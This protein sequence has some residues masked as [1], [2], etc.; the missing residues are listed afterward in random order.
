MGLIVTVLCTHRARR[1]PR[2][3]TWSIAAAFGICTLGVFCAVPAVESV[4]VSI[5]SVPNFAKIIA[6][7]C[8]I[9]WCA[10]L[11]IAMVDL[12][13]RPDYLR[14][15]SIQRSFVALIWLCIMVP[16]FLATNGPSVTFTT[17]HVDNP[18]IASYLLIY[19]TYV[20]ITC[21]ELAFMCGTTAKRNWHTRPWTGWGFALSALAAAL[22]VAY[23]VS[24][25]SYVLLYALGH[26][27]SLSVEE[28]LSPAFSGLAVLCLFGGLTL[29]MLGGAL[30]RLRSNRAQPDQ[31]SV[32]T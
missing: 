23:T 21:A 1:Q 15:A 8:A 5:T 13:Y 17:D 20:L 30:R 19:L 16:L 18:R 22:G 14:T 25:G 24:K 6:H 26:P 12:A 3:F 11:Q 2:V 28:K 31:E 29:P 10:S 4:A 7:V 27:Y 32:S 9:L